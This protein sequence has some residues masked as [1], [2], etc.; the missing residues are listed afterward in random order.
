MTAASTIERPEDGNNNKATKPEWIQD[1]PFP[2]KSLHKKALLRLL[3]AHHAGSTMTY[4]DLSLAIGVGEKTKS[5]QCEAW[6][7]L[8]K[9]DFIVLVAADTKTKKKTY[10]LSPQ[11]IELAQCFCS[12]EELAE[13]RTPLSNEELHNKIRKQLTRDSKTGKHKHSGRKLFDFLLNAHDKKDAVGWT[14]LELAYQLGTTNPDSHG[15]F[16]GFAALQKMKLV[17]VQGTITRDELKRKHEM[18][19]N[20][21]K[22]N[23]KGDG[24]GTSSSEGLEDA[25][26]APKPK[27]KKIRLRGGCQ[28]FALSEKAFLTTAPIPVE[29]EEGTQK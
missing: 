2:I 23:E 22:E 4:S 29:Q 5:W 12:P 17:R 28:L 14:R 20:V 1:L 7:H 24:V 9:N 25:A 6:K 10:G 26:T 18:L 27:K 15:F 16:Y 21:K 11:G 13:Y 3:Q 8:N 19:Q